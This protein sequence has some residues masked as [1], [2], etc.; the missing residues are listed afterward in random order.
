MQPSIFD[1]SGKTAFVTGG[2]TGLGLGIAKG[3]AQAGAVVAIQGR[4]EDKT[5]K[6]L[7]TL[8]GSSVSLAIWSV[9]CGSDGF[10][11][12]ASRRAFVHPHLCSRRLPRPIRLAR[13]MAYGP[14]V[15][16]SVG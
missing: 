10:C 9:L 16:R 5:K 1:L 7:E 2:N 6:A 15:G 3:L 14:S 12:R 4:S 8:H 13:R 11:A